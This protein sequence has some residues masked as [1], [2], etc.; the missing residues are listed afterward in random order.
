MQPP[1]PR[2]SLARRQPKAKQASSTPHTSGATVHLRLSSLPFPCI[3]LTV[4]HDHCLADMSS[5]PLHSL[6]LFR[7]T[8]SAHWSPV[9]LWRCSLV[10]AP[11]EPDH[12]DC[13]RAAVASL[14]SPSPTGIHNSSRSHL[15]IISLSPS[16]V[17]KGQESSPLKRKSNHPPWSPFTWTADP[18]NRRS[19]AGIPTTQ[20]PSNSFFPR[21]AAPES[22]LVPA[23]V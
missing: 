23:L 4:T 1:N 13:P 7:S 19:G 20:D 9:V 10:S 11:P 15:A 5:L 22:S 2:T 14:S 12:K 18:V 8:A 16:S 6:M 3:C 17:S 21:L